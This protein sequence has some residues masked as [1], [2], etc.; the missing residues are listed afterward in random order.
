MR[1]VTSGA[2]FGFYRSVFIS[3]RPLF[4]RVTLNTSGIRAGR[5]SGLLEFESAMRVMAIAA[6][7]GPFQNLMMEG[8]GERRLDLA[9]A[10]YTELRVVR[11]QHSD[12]CK[13]RLFTVR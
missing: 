6:T 12:G 7:H 3:K 5:Q 10:T 2:P 8:R 1:R 13:A 11:A 4:V 9:L